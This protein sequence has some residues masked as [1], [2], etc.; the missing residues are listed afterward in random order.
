MLF[1]G[2]TWYLKY[3]G[4][5]NVIE[6]LDELIEELEAEPLY[7]WKVEI[8]KYSNKKNN[9]FAVDVTHEVFFVSDS[10]YEE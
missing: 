3:N 10:N 9:Q 8:E 6:K 2:L 1:T 5:E 7:P 4:T